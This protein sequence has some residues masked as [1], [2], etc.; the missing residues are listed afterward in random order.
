M[1]VTKEVT[2]WCDAEVDGHTCGRWVQFNYAEA[3]GSATRARVVAKRDG[4]SSRP[5]G[6]IRGGNVTDNCPRHT[7]NSGR[8]VTD[9]STK[10][11]GLIMHDH[12]EPRTDC[13]SCQHNLSYRARV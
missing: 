1:S 7:A 12:I 2:L 9:K 8:D 4:W 3:G 11:M 10:T 5:G 6:T 13:I